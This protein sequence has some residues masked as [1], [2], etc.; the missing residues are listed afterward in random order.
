MKTLLILLLSVASLRAVVP[1]GP[2]TNSVMVYFYWDAQPA[3]SN[4]DWRIYYTT[5]VA[6]PTNQWPLFTLVTNAVTI[7]SRVYSTN[8]IVPGTYF[9]TVTASNFWSGETPFSVAAAS[10]PSPGVYPNPIQTLSIS[11]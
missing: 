1:I 4:V 10:G 6:T 2:A 11:R 5:N 9:F 7:G 8:S 3:A